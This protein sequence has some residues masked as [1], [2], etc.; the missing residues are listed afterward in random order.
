MV[1]LQHTMNWALGLGQ[2]CRERRVEY[3]HVL[4]GLLGILHTWG[5]KELLG[6]PGA[7]VC[8]PSRGTL[9]FRSFWNVLHRVKDR[10]PAKLQD[11]S[12]QRTQETLLHLLQDHGSSSQGP[13]RSSR[14]SRA[15]AGSLAQA[16]SATAEQQPGS[17]QAAA[18]TNAGRSKWLTLHFV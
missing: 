18:T 2:H 9:G 11:P 16:C 13:A 3:S 1:S 14:S 17:G 8:A 7:C 5:A 6:L 15:L 10:A 12:P 4:K